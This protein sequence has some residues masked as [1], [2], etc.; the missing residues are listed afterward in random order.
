MTLTADKFQYVR[1]HVRE[2]PDFHKKGI[3]FLDIT[4]ATKDAESMKYMIDFFMKNSRMK[5]LITLQVLNHADSSSAHRLLTS[6]MQVL[7]Q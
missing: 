1:D 3:L 2:V 6:L 7:F 4:T 5:R